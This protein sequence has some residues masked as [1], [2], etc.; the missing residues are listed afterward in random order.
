LLSKQKDTIKSEKRGLLRRN[1][2]ISKQME[3]E[4]VALK[5]SEKHDV[6]EIK[7]QIKELEQC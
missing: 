7:N 5:V 1:C 6:Y 3:V 2:L 4:A